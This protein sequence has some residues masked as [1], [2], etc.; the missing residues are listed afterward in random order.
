MKK[1]IKLKDFLVD[2]KKDELL[3]VEELYELE[4][5]LEKEF[6]S[7]LD[8]FFDREVEDREVVLEDLDKDNGF[9]YKL[10]CEWFENEF[11]VKWGLG[12]VWYEYSLESLFRDYFGIGGACENDLF[13]IEDIN[14]KL[15]GDDYDEE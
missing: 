8:S 13:E 15:Y 9:L 10:M 14:K 2:F 5:N 11:V 7:L 4:G 3:N 12:L 6:I 1:V